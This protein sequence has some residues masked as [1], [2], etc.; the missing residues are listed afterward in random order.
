MQ[1]INLMCPVNHLGYGVAGYNILKAL[2]L[3]G[4]TVSF[5]PIGEPKWEGDPKFAQIV[6]GTMS[7]ARMFYDKGPAIKI[8]HQND[9]ALFPGRGPRIGFPIF[10]LNK[11]NPQELL[12][13]NSLDKILVCSQW[14]KQVVEDNGIKVPTF[15]VPLGV[16]VEVFHEIEKIKT[17]RPYWSKNTTVFMNVGK[18]EIR[19]GHKE[20][21]KAFNDAFT[22]QDDVE[23][24]MMNDNPFIGIENELWK[25]EYLESKLGSKIKINPRVKTQQELRDLYNQIDFG[26]FPSHAE[27]WNL[28]P[29]E[30]MAC[31]ADIIATNYSGH[32]EYL[33]DTNSFLLQPVGMETAQDGKWFHGN[34]EWCKISTEG[35]KLALKIAHGWKQDKSNKLPEVKQTVQK[36]S[37]QNS[38]AKLMEAINA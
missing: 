6:K 2:V 30:M 24:W 33:N 22:E 15:V 35:L 23:L 38:A 20:L 7:N 36:F 25:K 1:P 11:F 4:E 29:L 28:E 17:S 34:G 31:G 14:A 27:G 16:D 37:W 12:H 21:L 18:W 9:M 3:A 13:L 5:F 26:V 10:E 19:K 8:W 32:T